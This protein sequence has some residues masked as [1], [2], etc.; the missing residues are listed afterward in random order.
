VANLLRYHKDPAAQLQK[1][2]RHQSEMLLQR[3]AGVT[4]D[5]PLEDDKDIP[6]RALPFGSEDIKSSPT[7]VAQSSNVLSPQPVKPGSGPSSVHNL[8]QS[9][10]E[11]VPRSNTRP[12][13]TDI[14]EP[15]Y[16]GPGPSFEKGEDIPTY[17]TP[18]LPTEEEQD[19]LDT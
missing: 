13:T 1:L 15:A 16:H 17:I 6:R 19:I 18:A 4:G 3:F 5:D 8:L 2:A 7:Y 10:P 14:P 9:D 11:A 12:T